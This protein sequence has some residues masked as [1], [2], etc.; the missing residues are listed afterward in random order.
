MRK[1]SRILINVAAILD[2]VAIVILAFYFVILF[3]ALINGTVL[4]QVFANNASYKALTGTPEEIAKAAKGL[5]LI[6]MGVSAVC[7]V[8]FIFACKFA[9]ATLNNMGSK[10][11]MIINIV[12]G[13]MTT[14]FAAVGGIL[15]LVGIGQ[16]VK[17]EPVEEEV[18]E[19]DEADQ[20]VTEEETVSD[21]EEQQQL[22]EQVREQ[23]EVQEEIHED[24]S[25]ELQREMP[26][27]AGQ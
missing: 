18:A 17:V 16:K 1:T 9:F 2:I 21:V 12:F 22:A 4:K 3:L 5:V 24:L 10:K 13:L 11:Y 8:V 25:E 14:L 15:G 6:G 19:P 27:E 7:L 20:P 26:N 23:E